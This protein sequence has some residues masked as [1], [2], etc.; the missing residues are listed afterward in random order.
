MQAKCSL[1]ESKNVRGKIKCGKIK[2]S[3]RKPGYPIFCF[4]L[5]KEQ[6]LSLC[7]SFLGLFKCLAYAS[8]FG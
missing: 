3:Q 2:Y 6:L 7:D 5:G 1:Y 8:S 4:R